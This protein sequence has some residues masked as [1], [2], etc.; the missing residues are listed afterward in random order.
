MRN[1]LQQE[2]ALPQAGRII[3]SA[4]LCQQ[5]LA[6][7]PGQP[8]AL[9]LLALVA[10]NRGEAAE[11]ERLF[12]AS[13]VAAPTADVLVNYGVF[14][15]GIGRLAEAE[16]QLRSAGKLAPEFAAGWHNLGLLLHAAGELQEASRC[17]QT[18]TALEPARPSGWE[19]L[20][21]IHQKQGDNAGAI[22]ACE[23]GLV[24]TPAASRLHYSRAQLLRQESRFGEAAA[25]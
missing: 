6:A 25:A 17:A 1:T 22:A 15:R 11:A 2:A 5:V 24:H 3:D 8:D 23:Q 7:V 20:A 16:A 19:L 4:D 10:R 18:L 21:A 13:I 9:H 12:R 14:L